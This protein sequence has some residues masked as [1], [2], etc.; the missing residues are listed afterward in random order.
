MPALSTPQ[1]DERIVE[2]ESPP[3]DP[4]PE[5]SAAR[6]TQ[7]SKPAKDPRT[8]RALAITAATGGVVLAGIGFTGSYNAL[9]HLA[10]SKGFG[11]FAY[12][13][14]VGIDAGI[15]VLL[16]M[17]LYLLRRRIRLPFLRWFAHGLTVA[18][19][20][21]NAAA[22]D[23]PLTADP[24]AAAMHGVIPVLFIVAVEAARHCIGRMAAILAGEQEYGSPPLFRWLLSPLPTWFLFRRM[25]LWDLPNYQQV[26]NRQR[27]ITIYRQ[28]L[29]KRYGRHAWR[30]KTPPD[31]LLPIK[32][33][34]FG[35]SVDEALEIPVREAEAAAARAEAARL[36]EL[37]AETSRG[38]RESEEELRRIEMNTRI[39]VAKLG[40][41][42]EQMVA[43]GR[44][45]RARKQLEEAVE[46]DLRESEGQVQLREAEA[47]R[48]AQKLRDQTEAE[49][50]Q[51]IHDRENE[52][53]NW[54]EELR[55]REAAAQQQ[56]AEA[57]A[58]RIETEAAAKKV[59]QQQQAEAA[60]AERAAAEAQLRTAEALKAAVEAE[61]EA[62]KAD[63]ERVA[64]ERVAAQEKLRTSEIR[65][66]EAETERAIAEA[67][68][69][70]RLSLP[71]RDARRI[72]RMIE[73]RGVDRV[74]LQVIVDELGVS[75]STASVRRARAIEYLK[76]EG[77][78][79]PETDS[80]AA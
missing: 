54:Q 6:P 69:E 26:V 57:E 1:L 66:Q 43:Q 35:L 60:E 25:R 79:L 36:R 29:R 42:Q 2:H 68:A 7:V 49:R 58:K 63:A 80:A 4:A 27:E 32:M 10:V 8:M 47:E 46:A 37:E 78:A 45:E 30:W 75:Q 41:M 9:R 16:A 74:T 18:T 11:S 3:P 56:A 71:E 72:A 53:L 52:Q 61:A 31:E 13:F 64:A 15:L 5:V 14:P 23:G 38:L 59:A 17:D 55:R 40:A 24:L 67:E 76:E 51:A 48:E 39:E 65:L 70:A 34:R 62:A 44:L 21:F 50:L 20:V 12:A 33:A 22:P 19:V 28:M 73:S 77:H